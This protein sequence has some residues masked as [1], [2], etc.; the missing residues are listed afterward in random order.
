MVECLYPVQEHEDDSLPE[1]MDEWRTSPECS[2]D[3][4]IEVWGWQRQWNAE[5]SHR[6]SLAIA[7]EDLDMAH[8][9]DDE[10]SV[11]ILLGLK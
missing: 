8:A 3:W 6:E 4:C 5:R 2:H 9:T 1:G 7:R 11:G 10:L